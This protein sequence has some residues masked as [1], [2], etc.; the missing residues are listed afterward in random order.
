MPTSAEPRRWRLASTLARKKRFSVTKGSN[1]SEA[2]VRK[3]AMK[4]CLAS[5]GENPRVIAS[6]SRK[7]YGRSCRIAR[8]GDGVSPSPWPLPRWNGQTSMCC[9][10]R[11]SRV[12]RRATSLRC[13]ARIAMPI[14]ARLRGVNSDYLLRLPPRCSH[15]LLRRLGFCWKS[16]HYFLK[17]APSALSVFCS[18]AGSAMVKTE[19]TPTSLAT[20][21]W[22]PI[23]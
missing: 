22:P 8:A 7:G 15:H 4:F 20:V 21:S 3:R 16:S 2:E 23:A 19:P 12:R 1:L 6:T 14:N 13:G 11:D 10:T 9:A 17:L 18:A 5:G